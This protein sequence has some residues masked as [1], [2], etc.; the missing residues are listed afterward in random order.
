[1]SGD[2]MTDE[3]RPAASGQSQYFGPFGPGPDRDEPTQ[4]LPPN[5]SAHGPAYA[6][7]SGHPAPSGPPPRQRPAGHPVSEP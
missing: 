7:P 6:P 5:P 3:D 2:E 1:M 4:P